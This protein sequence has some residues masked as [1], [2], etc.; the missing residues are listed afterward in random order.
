MARTFDSRDNKGMMGSGRDMRSMK[1][2]T[3]ERVWISENQIKTAQKQ[4][5]ECENEVKR[6]ALHKVMIYPK[7]ILQIHTE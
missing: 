3:R 5:V 1:G 6:L 2:K 7:S 4:P